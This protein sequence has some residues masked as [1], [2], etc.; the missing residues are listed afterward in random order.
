MLLLEHNHNCTQMTA[1]FC[2]GKWSI[3]E[4]FPILNQFLLSLKNRLRLGFTSTLSLRVAMEIIHLRS[5]G[6]RKVGK[7]FDAF[8]LVLLVDEKNF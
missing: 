5:K 3:M 1:I 6:T 2:H 7:N 4:N 8:T